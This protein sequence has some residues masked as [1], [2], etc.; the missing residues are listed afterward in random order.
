MHGRLQSM[1][2][3]CNALMRE[4]VVLL[5][6][7]ARWCWKGFCLSRYQSCYMWQGAIVVWQDCHLCCINPPIWREFHTPV[8]IF[9]WMWMTLPIAINIPKNG[10]KA[11]LLKLA[12]V[13]DAV[14][15]QHRYWME[16]GIA[17]CIMSSTAVAFW[18]YC[19]V[20]G[21]GL[22]ADCPSS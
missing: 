18:W 1:S 15:M 21:Q 17:L 16:V 10:L 11:V 9:H 7:C 19:G 8:S 22:Q 13:W 2:M 12:I 5:L 3:Y 4:Q 14:P 20:L 6:K